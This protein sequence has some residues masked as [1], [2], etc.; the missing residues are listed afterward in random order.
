MKIKPITREEN[1]LAYAAGDTSL[2]LPKP[3][4]R[5]ERYLY[6]LCRQIASGGATPEQIQEYVESYLSENPVQ[7]GATAE[8]A[9]QIEANR[10]AIHEL[11]ENNSEKPGEDVLAPSVSVEQTAV[12]AVI[13]ITDKNGT[14]T[15]T[16]TNGKDG[17]NGSEGHTPVK[18]ED[19]WTDSDRN[20]II[21]D[22]SEIS[23]AK[24][25]GTA[26]AGK[27]LV[28]GND[29]YLTLTDMPDVPSSDVVG[30]LDSSNS[31][32]LSGNLADGTYTL[33][34]ENMDGSYTEIG[35]LVVAP[36]GPSY[37]NAL[38]LAVDASGKPFVGANGEVGYKTGYRLSF[39]SGNE[40][41]LADYEVT[42]YIP[43]TYGAKIRIKNIHIPEGTADEMNNHYICFYDAN[44]A[45]LLKTTLIAQFVV[46]GTDEGNGVLM[47]STSSVSAT[48]MAYFRIC[49][50]EITED[51][52]I[53]VNEPIA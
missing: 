7:A 46:G 11:Q 24:N 13:V 50:S 35:N 32:I 38:T 34:Y 23:V 3:I 42:G 51:S 21:S 12:G 36:P 20:A 18:G 26:N 10:L 49:G 17:T 39:T 1:Y 25:Q 31:I 30:V 43:V 15:A 4:T 41:T 48:N 45:V 16:V 28:V 27:I 44:K 19:Y 8:Q 29:G 5:K 14:T 52:I 22:L 37:T 2:A 6:D 9:A 47:M 40:S 33:K 53:T